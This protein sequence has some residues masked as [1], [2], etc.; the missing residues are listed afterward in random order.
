MLSWSADFSHYNI[1]LKF[2]FRA[3][4][5]VF[6]LVDLPQAMSTSRVTRSKIDQHT[7]TAAAAMEVS[8]WP[9]QKALHFCF[10]TVKTKCL[11]Q[12]YTQ[13]PF[14]G[15]FSVKRATSAGTLTPTVE[16]PEWGLSWYYNFFRIYISSEISQEESIPSTKLIWPTLAAN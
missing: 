11:M 8:K 15:F 4:R 9:N 5:F 1:T 16:D 12:G 10:F 2:P 14:L 3:R 13:H 6:I 7:N